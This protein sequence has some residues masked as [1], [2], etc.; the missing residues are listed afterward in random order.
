MALNVESLV[1]S[2]VQAV[3]PVLAKHWSEVE[4]YA[5]TEAQKMAHALANITQLVAS[6]SIDEGQAKALLDMQK[7][8]SQAVLLTIE[9]I[10]LI[11]AQNAI[12]AALGAV[13]GVVNG[14]IGFPLLG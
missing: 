8:A 13:K 2:I 11:A 14:A 12:N 1:G 4:P 3:K 7:H 10:G 5:K 9:G 6:K